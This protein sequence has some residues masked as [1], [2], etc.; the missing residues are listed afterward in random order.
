MS[1]KPCLYLSVLLSCS[2]TA[3]AQ[4]IIDT[5]LTSTAYG[6]NF[7]SSASLLG[8]EADLLEWTGSSWLGAWPDAEITLAPPANENG[9]RAIFIGNGETWTTGGEGLYLLLDA[10]LSSGQTYSFDFTYVSHGFGSDG[11]FAPDVYTNNAASVTG[12]YQLSN[13]PP[14]DFNWTSNSYSFTATMAQDGHTFLAIHS[15]DTGSSGLIFQFCD[16]ESL[17]GIDVPIEKGDKDV[18]KIIDLMGREAAFKPNK[19]FI[20]IYSDGTRERVMTIEN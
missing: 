3:A 17:A 16:E 14:A 13:L 15:G 6:T 20:F 19:P 9:S 11:S 5:C 7:L 10:P 4:K 8:S 1:M 2:V 12:A 18:V